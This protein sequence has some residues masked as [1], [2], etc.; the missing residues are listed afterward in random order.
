[1]CAEEEQDAMPPFPCPATLVMVEPSHGRR[2][3]VVLFLE[4]RD[5]GAEQKRS[6]EEPALCKWLWIKLRMKFSVGGLQCRP[7]EASRCYEFSSPTQ[8]VFGETFEQR[9]ALSFQNE[10]SDE[11]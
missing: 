8:D 11:L 1:V 5:G 4:T 9:D 6:R 3:L 10:Y 7:A 2:G